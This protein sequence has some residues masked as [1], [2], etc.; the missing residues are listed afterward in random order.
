MLCIIAR[1]G[2]P[3][4]AGLYQ[5]EPGQNLV[6]N[7][8]VI[9]TKKPETFRY[10][11]PEEKFR[12]IRN[13]FTVPIRA[14]CYG[15]DGS[16][17]FAIDP[18]KVLAEQFRE[19]GISL[20]Y[21]GNPEIRIEVTGYALPSP[22][23]VPGFI[24]RPADYGR[25]AG[26]SGSAD[27]ASRAAAH[28]TGRAGGPG[29][30]AQAPRRANGGN[31]KTA[32]SART[33]KSRTGAGGKVL[34]AALTAALVLAVAAAAILFNAESSVKRLGRELGEGNY[35]AA[36][37]VYNEKI[38]GHG[39]REEKAD[40]QI[41]SAIE[42]I[43]DGYLSGRT[44]YEKACE[45]LGIL[46]QIGKDTLSDQAGHALEEVETYERASAAY[47]EGQAFLEKKEYVEAV[48]SFLEVPEAS[49]ICAD[50]KK[51]IGVCVDCLVRS[52]AGL[53]E[54]E[55]YP[56]VMGR[57]EAAM[58]LLPGNEDLAEGRETCRRNYENLVRTAAVSETDKLL[59]S[60]DY[61]GAFARIGQAQEILPED[62]ALTVKYGEC[63]DAYVR[64]ITGKVTAD[65]DAGSFG[66]AKTLLGE[67]AQVH[68]CGEFESLAAQLEAAV[69]RSEDLP[70][71]LTA[72]KVTFVKLNGT[73]KGPGKSV[74]HS[75]KAAESGEYRFSFSKM[76]RSFK[77]KIVILS[78]DGEETAGNPAVSSGGGITCSLE[79]GRKY[80]VEVTGTEGKGSYILTVGQPKAE[81]DLSGCD[82]IADNL[83]YKNQMNVYRFTAE[84]GGIY[85]FDLADMQ[86]G[87][88]AGMG[89]Y[90]PFGN[91]VR[92]GRG[93]SAGDGVSA[94]LSAGEQYE[95]H[96]A[97]SAKLGS[98]TLRI[99]RQKPSEDITGKNILPGTVAF[100]DQKILYTY[101]A[102]ESGQYRF[103]V[104]N[105]ET[106]CRVRFLVYDSLGYKIGG[107][108]DLAAGGSV[109]VEL[110]GGKPSQIRLIQSEGTGDYTLTVSRQ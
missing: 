85:R 43:G 105:M 38:L 13:G 33:E 60:G 110:T 6:N 86:E 84:N 88:K 44:S 109:T 78:P 82:E 69:S 17:L 3:N 96:V 22:E 71:I 18:L 66:D 83:E 29:N 75:F 91:L 21:K 49:T 42:T 61:A 35:Q 4:I 41:L 104:G 62:Q 7:I 107:D 40:P 31:V 81:S 92:G 36:V 87:V 39:T 97:Q 14:A 100:T 108:E 37:T 50:A 72:P 15:T 95:I 32:D 28:G 79:K 99:G 9:C 20:P 59:A 74:R 47:R 26:G 54:A 98:Y 94:E 45:E 16:F 55:D 10:F 65:V 5:I 76:A 89:I 64:H 48:R 90:D 77:V 25:R 11:V 57:I 2:E 12:D 27:K 58:E 70:R 24:D 106:S 8:R 73:I 46:T 68:P 53:R 19:A 80:T 34:R 67:A 23:G 101:T 93:L 51:Q 63:H 1:L 56:E 102:A 30:A 103:T 52:A